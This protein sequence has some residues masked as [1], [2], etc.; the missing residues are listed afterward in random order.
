M[1]EYKPW[2]DC[3]ITELEYFKNRCLERGIEI[4]SLE[5]RLK[6]AEEVIGL[7]ADPGNWD[8]YDSIKEGNDIPENPS[9]PWNAVFIT[10]EDD[11]DLIDNY[12]LLAGWAYVNGKRAREYFARYKK[13]ENE[14]R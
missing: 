3:G 12:G 8:Y 6:D 2:S 1:S 4:E 13:E 5:A 7:Y 14:H 10:D 11:S 9:T